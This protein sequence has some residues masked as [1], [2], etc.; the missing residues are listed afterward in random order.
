MFSQIL[1]TISPFLVS[2][3]GARTQCA[4]F[5]YEIIGGQVTSV[6]Y[7]YIGT[8]KVHIRSATRIDLSSEELDIDV[9]TTPSKGL[10]LSAGQVLNPKIKVIGTLAEPRVTVDAAGTLLSGGT[11]VFTGGASLVARLGLDRLSGS[12]DPCAEI[13]AQARKALG[14]RF[15]QFST[16]KQ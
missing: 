16:T 7:T 2:E 10:K 14:D 15:P 1:G 4:I 8:D 9:E 12:K 5:P 3:T 6:P 13:E 11:A